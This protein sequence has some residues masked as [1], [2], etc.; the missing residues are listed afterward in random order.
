MPELLRMPEVS[1]GAT[2][3]RMSEWLVK[4]EASYAA[5]DVLATIE[6][7]KAVVDL[8]AEGDGVL[9]RILVPAGSDA[10]VGAPIALVAD[11]G[12]AVEDVDA[13]LVAVTGTASTAASNTTPPVRLAGPLSVAKPGRGGAG[14]EGHLEIGQAQQQ[15]MRVF[16][17]PLARRMAHDA[18]IEL[19]SITGTG[20]NGRI[21]RRDVER[22][23]AGRQSGG[24]ERTSSEPAEVLAEPSAP[25]PLLVT[26]RVPDR[27]AFEAPVAGPFTEVPPS[28][29][30]LAIAERMAESKRT[31]PHYYLPRLGQRRGTDR[32]SRPAE[33]DVTGQDLESPTSSSRWSPAPTSWCLP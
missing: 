5:N 4:E 18:G 21:V 9:L 6:T 26:T 25:P 2:S 27:N 12:E 7:D 1:A 19:E 23:V 32:Y 30:R 28:R 15:A 33:R 8:P 22:A 14:G 11:L 3:A 13:A 31:V 17:S 29:A 24:P 20:P 16:L 10:V